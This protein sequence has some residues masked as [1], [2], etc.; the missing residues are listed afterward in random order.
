VSALLP[1][2]TFREFESVCESD[3]E[4]ADIFAEDERAEVRAETEE[5]AL[6]IISRREA[7]P[8]VR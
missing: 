4:L 5:D 8:G 3:G 7:S 2:A 6:K 1:G